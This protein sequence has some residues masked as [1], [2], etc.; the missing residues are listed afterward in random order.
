MSLESIAIIKGDT[1]PIYFQILNAYDN[2]AHDVSLSTDV[3][4]CK[5]RAKG[6]STTLFDTTCTK[7]NETLGIV[8]LPAYEFD[9]DAGRYEFEL[10]IDGTTNLETCENKIPVR[11]KEEFADVEED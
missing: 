3:V 10:Y 5:F 7:V 11:I 6:S 1:K 9:H 2:T 4:M 8:M